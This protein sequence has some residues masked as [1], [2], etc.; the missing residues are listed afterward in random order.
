MCGYNTFRSVNIVLVDIFTF[1]VSIIY[2]T[3]R[4]SNFWILVLKSLTTSNWLSG[5]AKAFI[6]CFYSL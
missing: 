1:L 2:L 3:G 4:K 6:A 5:L